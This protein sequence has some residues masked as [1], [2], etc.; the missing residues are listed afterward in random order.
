MK[1]NKKH[2]GLCDYLAVYDQMT[3]FTE[4]RES[5]TNDE[6]WLVEHLPVFTQGRHGKPEHLINPHHIPVVQSDRGGQITYHGPGQAVIYFL[7]DIKR[8]KIGI[9]TLVCQI[10]KSCIDLLH[11]YNIQSHTIENAPG[12]YVDNAKIAS[13]G[14]RVKNGKTYH[15]LAINTHMDLTPFSYINPC[16]YTGLKMTQIE[17]YKK[18]IT[19]EKVFSDY[20][21]CF[22]DRLQNLPI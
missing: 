14:L 18:N 13:L 3:S 12:I 15:G 6:I 4:S 5:T 8:L 19:V 17:D 10:E 22:Q 1:F 2:L 7:L 16:G 20:L 11:H 9:K 21:I